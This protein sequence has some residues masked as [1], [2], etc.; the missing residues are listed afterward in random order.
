MWMRYSAVLETPTHHH[1]RRHLAARQLTPNDAQLFDLDSNFAAAPDV[2]PPDRFNAGVMVVAPDA[3]VLSHMRSVIDTLPS[4]DGGDTGVC[5]CRPPLPLPLFPEPHMTPQARCLYAVNRLPEFILPTLVE[6]RRHQSPSLCVQC[7]AH[8]ALDDTRQGARLLGG[9][10]TAADCALLFHTQALGQRGG[11]T[12][13][14]AGDAMVGGVCEPA[15][16][17]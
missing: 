17:G 15:A 4:H 14:A 11:G 6:G 8:H 12:Q 13:G 2:F 10:E 3:S 9:S 1:R 7:T 16:A 5:K